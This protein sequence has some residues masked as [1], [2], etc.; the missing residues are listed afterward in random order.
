VGNAVLIADRWAVTAAHVARE[1]ARENR[2]PQVRFAGK[3]YDVAEIYVF[4]RWD[5]GCANDIALLHLSSEVTGVHPIPLYRGRDELHQVVYLVGAGT[6]GTGDGEVRGEDHQMRAA[7]SAIDSINT[8]SLFLGFHEPPIAT[9]LEGTAGPGDS[10]GPAILV[11]GDGAFLAGI[12]SGAYAG[13]N[14][15]ASYGAVAVYTRVSPFVG[16]TD[17]VMG[18]QFEPVWT[19]AQAQRSN[20]RFT[21]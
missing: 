1:V 10:G 11:R 19:R 8:S 5:G 20:N 12:G 2:K 14:G 21:H 15:P 9:E 4:P 17:A 13:S 3:E 18:D 16:W 6:T 7:T